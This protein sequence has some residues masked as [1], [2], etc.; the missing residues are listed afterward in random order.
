MKVKIA[1]THYIVLFLLLVSPPTAPASVDGS[2]IQ[3]LATGCIDWSAGVA[4]AKGTGLPV[5][6]DGGQKPDMPL[7]GVDAARKMARSRLL[8]TIAAIRIDTASRVSDRMAE[9]EAFRNGLDALVSNAAV[10]HQEYLSDGTV[11]IELSMN[12]TGGF[13]QFVLP[14][15]IRQV[16]AVTTVVTD[17]PTIPPSPP[18]ASGTDATDDG[19]YTGLILDATGIGVHPVLVPEIVDESGA[20]IFGSAFVSREFAVSRGM[21]GF[22]TSK[23]AALKAKRVGERPIV[24]R[25]IRAQGEWGATMVIANTDAARLRSSAAHLDFLKACR[26]C[27]IIESEPGGPNDSGE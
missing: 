7:Q 5:C 23:A 15:E 9:S 14:E 22:A 17:A 21:S 11:E 18:T 6:S 10:T 16:D 13:A 4:R 20:V 2:L 24:V 12:L 3:R 27:I 8:E 26:V 1:L 25:A 19:P